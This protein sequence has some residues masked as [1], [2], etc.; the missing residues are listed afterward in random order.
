MIQFCVCESLNKKCHLKLRTCTMVML[1]GLNT[2][3][4]H[5]DILMSVVYPSHALRP[6]PHVAVD[7]LISHS[8]RPAEGATDP[9]LTLSACRATGHHEIH[10]RHQHS[11]T[12][13]SSTLIAG[14]SAGE[15]Q[16]SG[17][18]CCDA[19]KPFTSGLLRPHSV[20]CSESVF[21]PALF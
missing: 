21:S 15:P 14:I 17:F 1:P 9:V 6:H 13:L 12:P 11:S 5:C 20:P 4:M 3:M 16:H 19:A 10:Q 8:R 18:L 7:Y 2:A